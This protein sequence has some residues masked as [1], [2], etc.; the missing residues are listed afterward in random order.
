MIAVHNE[1]LETGVKVSFSKICRW[2]GVARSTAYYPPKTDRRDRPVDQEVL[3]LIKDLI[4]KEPGLGVRMTWARLRSWHGLAINRKK[5]HRI[6]KLEGLTLPKRKKGARPRVAH[7]RSVAER[8]NQRWSTDIASVDCGQ[9]GW[10]AFVPVI[11]CHT[12]EVVGWELDRTARSKTA[13]RALENGLLAR[14][15]LLR[16]A[17]KGMRL[18]HD[19]G[20]VFGSRNY[21]A[22]VADYG[23]TQEY[24]APYTPE[25]NGLCER[26]IR[27]FKEECCWVQRFANLAE[28]RKAVET[29]ITFYNERRPHSALNYQSPNQ[30]M[31][32]AA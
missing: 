5:V 21:R 17:P 27:T 4:E 6:M 2:L 32:I 18:R 28:A 3:T 14:F 24:I 12:R 11:D 29:W 25:Q 9:D 1:C 19:N 30:A 22:L 10:C 15:G 20:L 23:L 7:S 13:E 16:G 8:P 26:F 31:K